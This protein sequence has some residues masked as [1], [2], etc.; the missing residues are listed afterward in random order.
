MMPVGDE[1]TGWIV[2]GAPKDENSDAQ[3]WGFIFFNQI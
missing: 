2:N 1:K 3:V